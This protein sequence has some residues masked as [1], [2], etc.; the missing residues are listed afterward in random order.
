MNNFY[1]LTVFAVEKKSRFQQKQQLV[2]RSYQI[3]TEVDF[4]GPLVYQ[5]SFPN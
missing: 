4:F 2:R 1:S 5:Y 3:I